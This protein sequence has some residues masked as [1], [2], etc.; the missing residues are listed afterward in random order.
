[1]EGRIRE[2]V[3]TGKRKPETRDFG[4]GNAESGTEKEELGVKNTA[5]GHGGG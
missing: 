5:P 2:K 3:E 4:I 1:M